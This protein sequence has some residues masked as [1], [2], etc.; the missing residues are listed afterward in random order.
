MDVTK[1]YK[2]R[3]FGESPNVAEKWSAPLAPAGEPWQG[4]GVRTGFTP[5]TVHKGQNAG[6]TGP[7]EGLIVCRGL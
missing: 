3:W 4:F 7:T 1:P 5:N 2:V 6:S